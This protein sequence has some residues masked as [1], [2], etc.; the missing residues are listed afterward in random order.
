MNQCFHAARDLPPGGGD[1]LGIIHAVAAARHPFQRL[2][3]D[4]EALLHLQHAY[5]VAVVHIA[6]G[7]NRNIEIK[8]LIA[9]V[10]ECFADIPHH[11]AAAQ[12]GTAYPIG[13]SVLRAQNSY[14]P[15]AFDPELVIGQKVVIL[16]QALRE[17]AGKFAHLV[18]EAGRQVRLQ[19]ARTNI[20][21][22]HAHAGN[23][24]EDI[25][26]HLALAE[27]IQENAH[28]SKVEGM[29]AQPDQ[30]AGDALQFGQQHADVLDLV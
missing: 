2:V 28:R 18:I 11:T 8:L 16:L 10:R 1:D 21:G 9:A 13:N 23:K 19:A 27:T 6:I 17:N 30:V 5:Q 7:A 25:Q 22:H 14:A 4:V 29:G 20:A 26:D 24:L 15:G 12:H 3:D